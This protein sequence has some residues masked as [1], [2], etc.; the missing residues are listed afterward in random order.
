MFLHLHKSEE[1]GYSRQIHQDVLSCRQ[2]QRGCSREQPRGQRFHYSAKRSGRV[3]DLVL[4]TPVRTPTFVPYWSTWVPYPAQLLTPLSCRCRFWEAAVV[5]R[6]R[7]SSRRT[8]AILGICRMSQWM[9]ILFFLISTV[10]KFSKMGRAGEGGGTGK[11][12]R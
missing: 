6:P 7:L 5:G 3:L 12:P 4:R 11:A 10:S 8:P 2:S 1:S 9:G